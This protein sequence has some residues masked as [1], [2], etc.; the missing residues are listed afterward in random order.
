MTDLVVALAFMGLIF[1]PYLFRSD[2]S[3][4]ERHLKDND[5]TFH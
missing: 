4:D 2:I 3:S 1:V 5:T